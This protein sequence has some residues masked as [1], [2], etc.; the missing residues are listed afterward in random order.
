MLPGFWG[1]RP[2]LSLKTKRRPALPDLSQQERLALSQKLRDHKGVI[3][4]SVTEN[5]FNSHPEWL[6]RFGSR[7]RKFCLEDAGFHLDFLAAAIDSD[8]LSSFEDYSRWLAR[9]LSRRNISREHAA[10]NFSQIGLAAQALLSD[11]EGV[12]SD[13]RSALE[14]CNRSG[15][16]MCTK[17]SLPGLKASWRR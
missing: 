14:L 1:W 13:V 7:G 2:S 4:Q 5:F 17:S 10:Q 11:R 3:A 8:S 6:T 12:A 15:R 9:L 16:T